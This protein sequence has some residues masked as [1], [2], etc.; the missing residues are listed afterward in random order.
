MELYIINNSEFFI[1]NTLTKLMHSR[2]FTL[3]SNFSEESIYLAGKV[4]WCFAGVR[5]TGNRG[6]NHLFFF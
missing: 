5:G 3:V 4:I 6:H 2:G 1:T